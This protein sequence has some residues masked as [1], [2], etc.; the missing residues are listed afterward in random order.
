MKISQLYVYPIKSLRAISL[1]SAEV[2]KH[3]FL[4]DRRFMILKVLLSEDGI[5]SLKNM[6]VTYFPEMV[7][8]FTKIEFPED[9]DANN[10]KI[11]V[12]FD[13]PQG[14]SKTLNVPL[15]PFTAGLDTL[16]INMH[17]SRTKAYD[18]GAQYDDWLS[19]CFGYEVVLAYLGE[20]KRPVLMST[21]PTTKTATSQSW[22]SSITSKL[23]M[24]SVLQG[25]KDEI[26]FSDCSPYLIVSE[27]SL[28][29]VSDR[30]P[31]GEE[32]DMTKFRPNIVVHGA[33]TAW[34]EDYWG[35]LTIGDSKLNLV[36]N[37]MRCQSINI[38]YATGKPATGEQGKVLKKLQ[39]DRRVDL[40][41]KYKAVF[42]RYAFL[43]PGS[44]G[45]TIKVGDE[46][47][48]SRRN[49]ER[50]KFDWPGL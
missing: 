45:R 50:T 19:S 8:F 44:A 37:C 47:L 4:Y 32:M 2:Y 48:V 34:D 22:L 43:E 18:M 29:D 14:E 6:H 7:R 25:E 23:P 38:D 13:P 42:G 24:P 20:N 31:E 46:V 40:G 26:T 27:T 3:G 16:D 15:V 1:P 11:I 35:E 36:H 10:A 41:A 5:R 33:E 28:G 30:L 39:S 49:E 17:G 12:T 9:G 21:N